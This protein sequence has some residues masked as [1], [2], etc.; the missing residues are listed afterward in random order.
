MSAW[1]RSAVLP[2]KEHTANIGN[3]APSF[4]L[5]IHPLIPINL[6]NQIKGFSVNP[7]SNPDPTPNSE[8]NEVESE[9]VGQVRIDIA[10]DVVP[11]IASGSVSSNPESHIFNY[12]PWESF[13]LPIRVEDVK[14]APTTLSAPTK[15]ITEIELDDDAYGKVERTNLKDTDGLIVK[16]D[17]NRKNGEP[18]K[19]RD[20]SSLNRSDIPELFQ[21]KNLLSPGQIKLIELANRKQQLFPL[22]YRDDYLR[23]SSILLLP[24]GWSSAVRYSMCSVPNLVNRSGQCKLHKYCPYCSFL[25]RQQA[26][27]RYV[28]VYD[29]GI[30]HFLTGSFVGDLHMTGTNS[31]YDLLHYWDA[32]KRAMYQLVDDGLVRGVFWTEE[33]AVNSIAPVHV[34][35]HIHAII[36]A[37]AMGEGVVEALTTSV[38]N[39]LRAA[40]GPDHLTP[41]FQIKS[42]NS[43]RKLLSHIQYQVKPIQIVRAYDVAWSRA[44]HNIDKA[45]FSSIHK[46]QIWYWGSPPLPKTVP[47]SIMPA[48]SHLS[49]NCILGRA[50]M[51]G[52]RRTEWSAK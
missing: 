37:D 6:M 16:S 1:K 26:L 8:L 25:S 7:I 21:H 47:N 33:L 38:I 3:T 50:K 18:D 48:T 13:T 36:E 32:Y 43:Q 5:I 44:V 11:V 17:S 39:N 51:I 20:F 22:R 12:K 30:W 49:A 2:Q 34:L 19:V 41:N 45:R 42:L 4:I 23:H 31:Y 24:N 10:G 15:A 29:S 40:I 46:P 35:P 9:I 14:I 27:A 28:P 52:R